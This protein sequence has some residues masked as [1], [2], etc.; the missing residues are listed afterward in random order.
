MTVTV[1]K[2]D[3]PVGTEGVCFPENRKGGMTLLLKVFSEGWVQ[4]P[5]NVLEREDIH[6]GELAEIRVS[7]VGEEQD[8]FLHCPS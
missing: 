7:R 8:R 2:G 3:Q 6:A 4:L 1:E 5:V